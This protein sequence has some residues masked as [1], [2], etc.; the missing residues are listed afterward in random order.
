M[1]LFNLF[2][3]VMVYGCYVYVPVSLLF[4]KFWDDDGDIFGRAKGDTNTYVIGRIGFYNVVLVT[5]P[6]MGTMNAMSTPTC[7]RLSFPGVKLALLIGV[8]G[9]IPKIDG[10]DVF[11]GDVV[12]SRILV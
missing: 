6:A 7:L 2:M 10:R 5:A 11:L 9:G 4:D 12:I 1:I 8:C 3:W